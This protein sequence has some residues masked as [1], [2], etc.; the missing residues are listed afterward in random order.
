LQASNPASSSEPPSVDAEGSD[1]TLRSPGG[2]V[3]VESSACSAFDL[4]DLNTFQER[5]ADALLAV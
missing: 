1:L 5:L 3:K 2:V 4:C